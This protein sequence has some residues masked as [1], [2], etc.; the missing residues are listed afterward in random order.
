MS[1]EAKDKYVQR[2]RGMS[3]MDCV[4]EIES[5]TVKW[6]MSVVRRKSQVSE[7]LV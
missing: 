2:P 3:A 6:A 7:V 4:G 1:V 5:L